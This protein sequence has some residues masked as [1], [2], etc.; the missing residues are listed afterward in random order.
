[1]NLSCSGCS[2]VSSLFTNE[3]QKRLAPGIFDTLPHILALFM[4]S[5]MQTA[6][7]KMAAFMVMC[8]QLSDVDF[9]YR[10]EQKWSGKDLCIGRVT[11]IFYLLLGYN[12][13][14]TDTE[15]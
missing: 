7:H 12:G 3:E 13:A 10:Q 5:L 6:G 4:T 1:M 9:F 11:G 8:L 2:Y 15:I 14:G